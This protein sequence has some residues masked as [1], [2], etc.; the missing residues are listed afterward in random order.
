RRT[1]PCGAKAPGRD[2]TLEKRSDLV[3]EDQLVPGRPARPAGGPGFP[4]GRPGVAPARANGR[5]NPVDFYNDPAGR[6]LPWYAM[7]GNLEL[8]LTLSG[9]LAAALACGFVT[10][11]VG[12]SPIVGYLVAGV[13]VGPNT[14]GFV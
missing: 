11:R 9:S 3:A 14:P 2:R 1:P 4:L 10:Y 7:H 12:L 8:I 5:P 13:A 6:P